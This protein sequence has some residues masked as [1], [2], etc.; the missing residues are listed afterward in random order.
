LWTA[1]DWKADDVNDGVTATLSPW[2][3]I[4]LRPRATIQH[5]VDTELEKR[6][7]ALAAL[8]GIVQ[9]LD[10]AS[11]RNLGDTLPFPV[12]LGLILVLGPF[13]GLISVYLWAWLLRSTGRW[14]G[15][16]GTLAQ[17]RT[18][19][20]WG[21]V[22]MITGGVLL[23]LILVLIGPELFT[24]S[25]PRLDAQPT[26]AIVVLGLILVQVVLTLW[27]VVTLLKCVAQVQR[28]S[29]W[30]A[31]VNNLIPLLIIFGVGIAAAIV[32]PMVGR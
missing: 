22:P 25:T 11:G 10:N 29:V 2:T 6:V 4:W 14:L 1:E 32:V 5:I 7:L 16:Q 17:L 21:S 23:L 20:A 15:G 26:L 19:I 18:A 24:E 12:V 3:S 9:T 28:F 27:S 30:R 8:S 13:V 31:L